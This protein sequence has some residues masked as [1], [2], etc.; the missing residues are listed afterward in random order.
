MVVLVEDRRQTWRLKNLKRV[1]QVGDAR[2]AGQI[3][4]VE[5]IICQPLVEVLLLPGRGP[6]LIGDV[7]ALDN[8]LTGR[9]AE[10]GGMTLDVPCRGVEDLPDALEIGFPVR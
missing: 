10:A 3:A 1:R 2:H 8:P 9:F 6:R 4:V 7:V 5:G